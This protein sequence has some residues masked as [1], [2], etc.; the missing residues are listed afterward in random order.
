[1]FALG[2]VVLRG[3]IGL[4]LGLG[5]IVVCVAA[6]LTVRSTDLFTAGVLPPLLMLALLVT[7]AVVDRSTIGVRALQPEASTLQVVIAGF[8]DQAGAMVVA[9]LLALVVVGMRVRAGRRRRLR[10]SN[11]LSLTFDGR[12][13]T[14]PR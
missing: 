6:A 1:V 13:A 5:F 10:T 7:L 12:H 14:E 4:L 11:P 3:H 2:E 8:V 9:H